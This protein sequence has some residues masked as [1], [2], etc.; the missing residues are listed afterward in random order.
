[1][2][3]SPIPRYNKMNNCHLDYYANFFSQ[4]LQYIIILSLQIVSPFLSNIFEFLKSFQSCLVPNTSSNTHTHTHTH[5]YIYIYIY[6]CSLFRFDRKTLVR[7]QSIFLGLNPL[8]HQ[9]YTNRAA[10]VKRETGMKASIWKTTQTIRLILVGN[11]MLKHI[12]KYNLHVFSFMEITTRFQAL[13]YSH[14]LFPSD[15][16]EGI[17]FLRRMFLMVSMLLNV[18]RV[19]FLSIC[20]L[21]LLFT[22]SFKLM[23]VA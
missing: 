10:H 15:L 6:I 8:C 9:R 16:T 20:Y 5:I 7:I 23:S 3:T 2:C 12:S 22:Q 17:F 4:E 18:S 1:M 11:I 21:Q 19:G 14:V 13:G